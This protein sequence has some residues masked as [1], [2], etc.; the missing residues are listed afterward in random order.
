MV[1]QD[2]TWARHHILSLGAGSE[3]DGRDDSLYS[4][5]KMKRSIEV[6]DK[7]VTEA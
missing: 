6:K 7:G 2:D 1:T 5:L 4:T 3:S